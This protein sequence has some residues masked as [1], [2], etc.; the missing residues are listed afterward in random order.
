[1]KNH[2]ASDKDIDS[3]L[4]LFA[5]AVPPDGM[6][7]RVVQRAR[8]DTASPRKPWYSSTLPVMAALACALVAAA[9]WVAKEQTRPIVLH[10]ERLPTTAALEPTAAVR[11]RSMKAFPHTITNAPPK[12]NL[13]WA[14]ASSAAG[15]AENKRRDPSR[16][17]IGDA[18]NAPSKQAPALPITNQE[19]LL[20]AAAHVQ[21]SSP[22]IA[23]LKRPIWPL[24]DP[25]DDEDFRR[26]FDSPTSGTANG[27]TE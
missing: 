18:T 3:A 19:R 23:G 25:A 8:A 5:Q 4:E 16:E 10:L 7:H 11:S 6:D 1:M 27:E 26:F 9:L 12:A 13:T 2:G 24:R 21:T 15:I 17:S 20:L 14:S 22:Q